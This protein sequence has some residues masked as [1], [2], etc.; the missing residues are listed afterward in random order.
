MHFSSHLM[1]RISLHFRSLIN[2]LA[3]ARKVHFPVKGRGTSSRQSKKGI[4]QRFASSTS[5]C[6]HAIRMVYSEKRLDV[7]LTVRD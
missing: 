7:F 2:Y 3:N 6:M 5:R 1:F 4:P